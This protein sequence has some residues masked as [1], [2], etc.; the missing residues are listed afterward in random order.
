MTK[1]TVVIIGATCDLGFELS[2]I[3][4][5]NN[6]D[7]IIISRDKEKNSNLKNS[8]ENLSKNTKVSSYEL[9]ILDLETHSKVYNLIEKPIDGVISLIGET[10][11]VSSIKDQRFISIINTNY[12]YLV[13]F[14]TFFLNDFETNNKGFLIC[15]S[16][17]AG[18]RG[19]KK[20][21]IYGSAKAALITFLSGSRNYYNNSNLF[22]MTVLPG[23]INNKG[24]K[25]NNLEK[26]LAI[27]PS[28]LANKIFV[29]HQQKK[30]V[31]YS[32][33]MWRMIMFTISLLPTIIFK[34]L[35]F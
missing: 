27:D 29:A 14:L 24:S 32:S 15:L 1:K 25:L 18:L 30:E 4:A 21:F 20:N 16:S 10:H 3:Y 12:T 8:I 2:K 17:V 11:N 6:Y 33:F 13:N 35:K 19:R 34:K 9:D 22:L 7:L 31:I 5:K 26:L 23:F 28:S